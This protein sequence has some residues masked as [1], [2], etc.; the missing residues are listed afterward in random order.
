MKKCK[1]CE[2][3]IEDDIKICP[4]CKANQNL[5]INKKI[6]Y[7]NN[8]ED[9]NAS[10]FNNI[11]QIAGDIRFLK[12]VVIIGLVIVCIIELINFLMMFN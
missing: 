1:F 11:T 10:I 4:Y 5:E 7:T 3:N 12:N 2:S 6:V 8:N 9:D